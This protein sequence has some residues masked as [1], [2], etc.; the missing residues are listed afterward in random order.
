V[1]AEAGRDVGMS[2]GRN[3]RIHAQ[4]H[5]CGLLQGCSSLCQR[6]QFRFALHVKQQDL[7]FESR[8]HFSL[9]L[10]DAGEDHLARGTPVNLEHTFQFAARNHV[11]PAPRSCDEAKNA[12][13]GIGFDGVA[14]RVPDFSERVVESSHPTDDA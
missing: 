9:G 6:P 10:P 5:G 2:V 13:A 3:I 4:S 12:K 14:D 11:E 1:L 7:R 8:P